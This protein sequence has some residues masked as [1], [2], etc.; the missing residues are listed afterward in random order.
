MAGVGTP[1][2]EPAAGP[3][4]FAVALVIAHEETMG[5]ENPK[6]GIADELSNAL[7]MAFN[8]VATK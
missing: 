8:G 5:A 7:K 1:T 6:I 2:L 4:G 3:K